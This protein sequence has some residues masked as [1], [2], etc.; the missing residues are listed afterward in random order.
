MEK[1]QCVSVKTLTRIQKQDVLVLEL[2]QI[3]FTGVV[4][5]LS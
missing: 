2:K 4:P 1:E 3:V 5:F